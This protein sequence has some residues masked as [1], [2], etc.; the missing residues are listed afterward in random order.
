MCA[1][2]RYTPLF[3]RRTCCQ[4]NVCDPSSSRPYTVNKV[5]NYY[6]TDMV[7]EDIDRQR[8][9]VL[10]YASLYM[11]HMFGTLKRMGSKKVFEI[12]FGRPTPDSRVVPK[13]VWGLKVRK[14]L[15]KMFSITKAQKN[16]KV[17]LYKG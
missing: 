14:S 1:Q 11:P 17:L 4:N 12:F 9:F 3:S 7:P 13:D 15:S 8:V 16:A 2:S 5:K 10:K 6:Y